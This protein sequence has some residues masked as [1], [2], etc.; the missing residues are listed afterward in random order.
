VVAAC[1]DG[2]VIHVVNATVTTLAISAQCPNPRG[3]SVR[4]SDGA[5]IAACFAGGVIQVLNECGDPSQRR[6]GG[7]CL[8]RRRRDS[9]GQRDRDDAG[10]QRAVSAPER[11]VDP[12]QRRGGDRCLRQRRRRDSSAQ[13]D[14]DDAGHKRA[15]PRPAE[16]V[17]PAQRRSR[18]CI[19]QR[20][21]RDPSTRRGRYDAG[22]QHAV[23]GTAGRVR[24]TQRRGRDCRLPAQRRRDSSHQ[25]D[26]SD[27]SYSCAVPWPGGVSVRPSDGAVVVACVAGG[28]I[29]VDTSCAGGFAVSEGQCQPCSAGSARQPAP[30]GT[31][32]APCQAGFVMPS[33]QAWNCNP[34]PSGS[35]DPPDQQP[36]LV[37][38]P[39][40][41]GSY[42]ALP[43]ATECSACPAGRYG[44]VGGATSC[45][46]CAAGRAAESNGTVRCGECAPVHA[47]WPVPPVALADLTRA[48]RKGL[49]LCLRRRLVLRALPAGLVRAERQR[50]LVRAVCAAAELLPVHGGT[51]VQRV[52]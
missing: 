46:P 24:P 16:R 36:S 33:S 34:V 2:G 29:A 48:P 26:H 30:A 47:A 17:R 43:A 35:Y 8:P 41:P 4:P 23:R 18:N 31:W 22:H 9:C 13:R 10:Q 44:Q 15:L 19:L 12:V 45:A 52:L 7:R 20:W 49:L 39:C 28:V 14:R 11:R 1:L 50:H 27:A 25:R 21:W 37:A 32:C 38:F 42:S 6:G 3:V 5:V 40:A 51:A